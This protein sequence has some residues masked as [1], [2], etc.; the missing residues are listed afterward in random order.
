[1]IITGCQ[2]SGTK[3]AAYMFGIDH[4]KQFT[5][6]RTFDNL[7]GIRQT[8]RSES[9]WMA[10]PFARE[11]L[12]WKQSIIHLVRHPILVINSLM[13]IEFWTHKC[14]DDFPQLIRKYLKETPEDPLEAS[15]YYWVN[16]NKMIPSCIPRIRIEDVANPPR[17]NG[18]QRGDI[19]TWEDL[20]EGELK[21]KVRVLATEYCYE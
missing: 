7:S 10:M 15:M 18:R 21:D 19:K 2:R 6:Y 16:W 12:N 20:P 17:L 3:S 1:M 14:H 9:S 11:L 4:E 13:G 5:K 8:L